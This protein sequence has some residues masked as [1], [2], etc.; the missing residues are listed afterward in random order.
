MKKKQT[1]IQKAAKKT[2]TNKKKTPQGNKGL[3]G[4]GNSLLHQSIIADLIFEVRNKADLNNYMPLSELSIDK[5]GINDL[6]KKYNL[7]FVILQKGTNEL[8]FLAE[9][10]KK[11][12]QKTK[13][14][15]KIQDCLQ[16]IPSLKE[17]FLIEFDNENKVYF[18][19]F[20]KNQKS[21]KNEMVESSISKLL[22]CDLKDFLMTR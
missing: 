9:I 1:T 10:T 5:I 15:Q 22:N 21:K 12:V 3:G 20:S 11:G 4:I 18:S 13:I 14:K 8:L 6:Q 17:A 7:D 19:F 2:S 16:N